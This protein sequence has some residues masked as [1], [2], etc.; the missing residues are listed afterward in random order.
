MYPRNIEK[1]LDE[2]DF[3]TGK[4]EPT[5]EGYAIAKIAVAKYRE[6]ISMQSSLDYKTNITCNL[7]KSMINLTHKILICL[8]V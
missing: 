1:E 3:H 5:N 7:Y 2:E 4:L 8:R 6:F